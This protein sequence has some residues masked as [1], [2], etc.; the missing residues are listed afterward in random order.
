MTRKEEYSF[1]QLLILYRYQAKSRGFDFNLT[2]EQFKSLTQLPC[3]YCGDSFTNAYK[4]R[5]GIYLYNG[6]DRLN[7]AL[8]YEIENCV[9]CCK[10]HN[11]MKFRMSVQE[12]I[13][14]CRS[15]VD[16]ADRLSGVS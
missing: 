11:R 9:A 14:A 7:S 4:R 13:A 5:K 3:F 1:D 10:V 8:G 16:R 2:K 12:F 15:V 6:V